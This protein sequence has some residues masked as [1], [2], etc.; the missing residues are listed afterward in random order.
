MSPLLLHAAFALGGGLGAAARHGLGRLLVHRLPLA[1]LIVNVLGSLVLGAA[2]ASVDAST[3]AAGGVVGG[4]VGGPGRRLVLGFCG[5]FTTFSS[6]AVQSLELGRDRSA[7]HAAA[8][9]ALNLGLCLGAF[10]LGGAAFG[11]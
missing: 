4:G 11:G 3:D 5:G 7:P 8:N 9:V 10:R 6:F 1:T 2:L